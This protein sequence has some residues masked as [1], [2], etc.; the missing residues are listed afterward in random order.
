MT[1]AFH[2]SAL[3]T[4]PARAAGEDTLPTG[5]HHNILQINRYLERR[6]TNF[7]KTGSLR[8]FIERIHYYH[9]EQIK[10]IR[11]HTHETIELAFVEYGAISYVLDQREYLVNRDSV[12]VIPAAVPHSL[13]VV[14]T[15]TL[16]CLFHIEISTVDEDGR[17]FL[18]EFP[19]YAHSQGYKFP[20][21]E[22]LRF[23]S[24]MWWHDLNSQAPKPLLMNKLSALFR[25]YLT[26]VIQE[27]FGALLPG[28]EIP[29]STDNFG[30]FSSRVRRVTEFLS[31]NIEQ[32]LTVQEI[33]REFNYSVQ[34]LN[35]LFCKEAGQ[36]LGKYFIGQKLYLARRL[37]LNTDLSIK[38][39]GCKVGYPDPGHFCRVFRN[40]MKVSPGVWRNREREH[41]ERAM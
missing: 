7:Y 6:W 9:A 36:T 13:S 41:E 38:E 2:D 18:R 31:R 39:I 21:I 17:K 27:C 15:P 23:I 26:T 24:S 12:L 35:R 10:Q 22:A 16:L 40:K 11:E 8:I 25:L 30:I 28:E 19:H 3:A 34:H 1:S 33:A 29:R 5:E 37:L 4:A 32:P 14:T 20:N